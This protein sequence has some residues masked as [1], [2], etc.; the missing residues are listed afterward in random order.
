MTQD[1]PTGLTQLASPTPNV[2][3]PFEHGLHAFAP[4]SLNVPAVQKSHFVSP[5]LTWK[6]PTEQGLQPLI[7][8]VPS[9]PGGQSS[10]LP[11][12]ECRPKSVDTHDIVL[13]PSGGN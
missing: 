4:L 5:C 8:N 6:V 10:H 1:R 7:P 13:G 3:V 12:T 2:V 11:F 9:V